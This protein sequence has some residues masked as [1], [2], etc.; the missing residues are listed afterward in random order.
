[1]EKIDTEG[2]L[3]A[4]EQD[5]EERGLK[6]EDTSFRGDKERGF[7]ISDDW[8]QGV[9]VEHIMEEIRAD[10]DR[11]GYSAREM[12]SAEQMANQDNREL[13]LYNEAFLKAR[14]DGMRSKWENPVFF[15]YNG[16]PIK[17]FFQ[18]IIR[19]ITA[20]AFYHSF[21]YQNAFNHETLE[22]VRQLQLRSDRLE[23]ECMELKEQ[24]RKMGQQR[25][26]PSG[27]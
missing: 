21:Q 2:I 15:P 4:V 1:M 9:D 13:D 14:M 19:K 5:L 20:S 11:Q 18:K 25:R 22:V 10:V 23:E 8:K 26:D 3:S 27:R 17:V 12:R 7:R 24:I 6:L 16:H